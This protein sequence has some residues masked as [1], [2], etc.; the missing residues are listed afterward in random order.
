MRWF[1]L[2]VF[3]LAFVR[4]VYVLKLMLIE[5]VD[6]YTDSI[7]QSLLPLPLLWLGRRL[8]GGGNLGFLFVSIHIRE[9]TQ[10]RER[11]ELKYN[12]C[13]LEDIVVFRAY[14]MGLYR[15]HTR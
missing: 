8:F 1:V 4:D 12:R 6:S 3:L 10:S 14:L 2:L 7:Q 15:L 5:V 11:Q 13:K 9:H